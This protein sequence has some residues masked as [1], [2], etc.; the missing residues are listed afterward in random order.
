MPKAGLTVMDEGALLDAYRNN[1]KPL[2]RIYV[3]SYFRFWRLLQHKLVAVQPPRLTDAGYR[4]A[5][6]IE[7]DRREGK[8]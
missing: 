6:A 8:P 4:K 1:P 7:V 5:R 3:Q 2:E